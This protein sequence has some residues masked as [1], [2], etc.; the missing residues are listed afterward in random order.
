M[1]GHIPVDFAAGGFP[2]WQGSGPIRG[3][4][5]ERSPT[6]VTSVGNVSPNQELLRSIP[7]STQERGPSSAA[8]AGKASPTA[9]GSASTTAQS[10]DWPLSTPEKL[11]PG[12][13]IGNQQAV[14]V[15]L[16]APGPRTATRAQL[17]IPEILP[18][19]PAPL[20]LAVTGA[21]PSQRERTQAVT[22]RGFCT[23]VKTAACV[24]RMPHRGTDTRV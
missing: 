3:P 13:R 4:T 16:G 18:L 15:R 14:A 11:E 22:E 19:T 23:H 9:L 8:S 24:L 12:T 6:A 5:R 17:Q 20:C 7:A 2:I 1:K 10:T 21:N